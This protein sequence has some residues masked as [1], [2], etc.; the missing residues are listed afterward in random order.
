MKE[1]ESFP[2]VS[3]EAVMLTCV[4]DA[5]NNWDVAI[6][7]IPMHSSRLLSRMKRTKH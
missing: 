3:L 6:V 4:V 2:T 7:D 5:N 1:D